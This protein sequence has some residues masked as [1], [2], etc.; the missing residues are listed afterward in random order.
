MSEQCETWTVNKVLNFKIT[1]ENHA[2]YQQKL[3]FAKFELFRLIMIGLN[4]KLEYYN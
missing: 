2:G 4:F 3:H 1:G